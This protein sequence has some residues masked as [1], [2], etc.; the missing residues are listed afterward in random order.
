L[1]VR[2]WEG[3]GV[4]ISFQWAAA[5]IFGLGIGIERDVYELGV[6]GLVFRFHVGGAVSL[7]F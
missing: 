5:S 2:R 7:A 4:C 6:S 3:P 1:S